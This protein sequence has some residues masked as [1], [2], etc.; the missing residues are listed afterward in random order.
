MY[1]VVLTTS[2]GGCEKVNLFLDDEKAIMSARSLCS[3]YGIEYS[4]EAKTDVDAWDVGFAEKGYGVFIKE[5]EIT[6]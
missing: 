4:E 5:T 6:Y 2:L 1:A 3:E